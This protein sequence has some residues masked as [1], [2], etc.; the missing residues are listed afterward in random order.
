MHKSIYLKGVSVNNYI[1]P[2]MIDSLNHPFNG[3]KANSADPDQTP[4]NAVSDPV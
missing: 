1:Y 4:H 2:G 3:T